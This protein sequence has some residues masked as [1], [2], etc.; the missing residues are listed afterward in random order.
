MVKQILRR[1]TNGHKCNVNP[2][3]T[4]TPC[5]YNQIGKSSRKQTIIAGEDAVGKESSYTADRN[6]NWYNHYG[7][8]YTGSSK[9]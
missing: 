7:N 4:K 2:N 6:V 3:N 9:N 1:G 5:H 8:Q